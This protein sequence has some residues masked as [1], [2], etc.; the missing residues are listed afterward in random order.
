MCLL[1]LTSIRS[2]DQQRNSRAKNVDVA[3]Q[4]STLGLTIPDYLRSV[5]KD[6]IRGKESF[7]S[8]TAVN[9]T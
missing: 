6:V 9:Y 2:V 3:Y 8:L 1:Y 7:V 5:T 4:P